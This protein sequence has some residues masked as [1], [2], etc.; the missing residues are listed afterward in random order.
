ML[1][2]IV[3]V[4][5]TTKKAISI[6][7][8]SAGSTIVYAVPTGKTFVGFVGGPNG[9]TYV[10]LNGQNVYVGVATN[11]TLQPYPLTLV[12]G[13]TFAPGNTSGILMGYEQ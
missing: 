4:P 13:T 2:N 1:N 11:G 8:N 5:T 9:A 6:N 7:L 10:L 3:V 12:E